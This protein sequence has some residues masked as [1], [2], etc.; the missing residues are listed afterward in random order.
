M[1]EILICSGGTTNFSGFRHLP[2]HSAA[3]LLFVTALTLYLMR[4]KAKSVSSTAVMLFVVI[5]TLVNSIL[6]D[7]SSSGASE[8]GLSIDYKIYAVS[9]YLAI[10]TMSFRNF[11]EKLLKALTYLSTATLIVWTLHIGLGIGSFGKA[12]APTFEIFMDWGE[13]MASIYWEPGQYQIIMTFTLVLFLDELRQI[14]ISRSMHYIKKFGIIVIAMLVCRSTMAYISLM[15]L[16]MLSFMFNRSGRKNTILYVFMLI[17]AAT[18]I[19]LIFSSDVV[20]EKIDPANLTQKSSLYIRILDNIALWN[21][22]QVSPLTGLGNGEEYMKY[23]RIF[24]DITSSNGWLAAAARYGWPFLSI[25]VLCM[26]LKLRRMKPGIPA[27]IAFIPLLISHCNE[28]QILYPIMY[29]YLYSFKTY[30]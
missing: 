30:S 27:L 18:L 4:P 14:N 17:I 28:H 11:R 3:A 5:W 16:M 6:F 10:S 25:I 21:M 20:Q 23:G 22:S 1:W 13:R 12:P 2:A 26:L 8:G 7:F 15:S 24:N 9:M 19:L 29:M